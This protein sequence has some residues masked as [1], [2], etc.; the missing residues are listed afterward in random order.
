MSADLNTSLKPE[1][2]VPQERAALPINADLATELASWIGKDIKITRS[3]YKG[4]NEM[5]GK[6]TG[7]L[8]SQNGE[9]IIKL[10]TT[11]ERRANDEKVPS[12]H[13]VPF[14]KI[15]EINHIL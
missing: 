11:T 14:S 13:L 10:E 6:M 9:V 3:G 5:F 12:V 7:L 2:F 8:K 1:A 4:E 15:F